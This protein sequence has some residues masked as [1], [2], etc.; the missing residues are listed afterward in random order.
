VVIGCVDEEL[1]TRLQ[2]AFNQPAFRAYTS[3]DVIGIELGEALK[4]I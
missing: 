1:A 3:S 2:A 4:N